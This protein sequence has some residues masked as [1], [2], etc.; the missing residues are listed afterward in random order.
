MLISLKDYIYNYYLPKLKIKN[1]YTGKYENVFKIFNLDGS[2][3]LDILMSKG[4]M[5]ETKYNF[6]TDS[7]EFG[8]VKIEK[9]DKIY[10]TKTEILPIT[11]KKY[12]WVTID[13]GKKKTVTVAKSYYKKI[14]RTRYY[15][16]EYRKKKIPVKKKIKEYYDDIEY[17]IVE[18]PIIK[19]KSRYTYKKIAFKRYIQF[20]L[21][22]EYKYVP[23]NS[24]LEHILS[25]KPFYT[26]Y[27]Y[28]IQISE[29]D[30]F[31]NEIFMTPEEFTQTKIF[32]DAIND[33]RNAMYVRVS[34]DEQQKFF[35]NYINYFKKNRKAR[36]KVNKNSYSYTLDIIDL[37]FFTDSKEIDNGAGNK[38]I[39]KLTKSQFDKELS[40]ND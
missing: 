29:V 23:A 7:K 14:G 11:V 30:S 25:I 28:P 26:R 5:I 32:N 17:E 6:A 37:V 38:E 27:S 36:Q 9:I 33:C 22:E 31:G 19:K 34:Q 18:T 1:I 12:R 21:Y 3:A 20:Y 40:D 8:L 24:K 10:T 39:T 16:T 2:G 4:Y 13:T 15:V 35:K